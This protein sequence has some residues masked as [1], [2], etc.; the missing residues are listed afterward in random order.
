MPAALPRLASRFLSPDHG[1]GGDRRLDDEDRFRFD[2]ESEFVD[3]PLDETQVGAASGAG[4]RR[5]A[6]KNQ[7]GSFD[8]I[9]VGAV[10]CEP[11]GLP[12]FVEQLGKPIL[13]YR[14]LAVLEKSQ[15]GSV[16]LSQPHLM[17]QPGQSGGRHQTDVTGADNR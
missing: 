4:R 14:D 17:T 3:D 16:G 11:A 15:S 8:G 13:E 1:P 6:E 9:D 5:K 7:T 10:E 2:I 12:G